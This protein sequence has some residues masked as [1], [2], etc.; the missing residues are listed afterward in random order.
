MNLEL[1]T[2]IRSVH[3]ETT[4]LR[5]LFMKDLKNK[6]SF[7]KKAGDVVERAGEKISNAGAK[8]IGE[9]VYNAGD[10]L[11]H[12]NDKKRDTVQKK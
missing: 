12:M 10:K 4:I 3:N 9:A 5:R 11:E 1:L 2:V 8:K 6:E 7:S